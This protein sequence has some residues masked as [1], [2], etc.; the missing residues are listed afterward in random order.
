[1]FLIHMHSMTYLGKDT[2]EQDKDRHVY[3]WYLIFSGHYTVG[4]LLHY[5]C[6]AHIIG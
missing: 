6:L 2:E 3:A 5:G 1:M 4:L